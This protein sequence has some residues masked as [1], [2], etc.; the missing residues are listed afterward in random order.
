MRHK[1]PTSAAQVNDSG[2][3]TPSSDTGHISRRRAILPPNVEPFTESERRRWEESL[4][5]VAIAKG[6]TPRVAQ[7]KDEATHHEA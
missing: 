4:Q 5:P 7:R 3:E 2:F 6:G 1:E